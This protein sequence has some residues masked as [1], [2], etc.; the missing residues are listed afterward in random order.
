MAPIGTIYFSDGAAATA[1]IKAI[2]LLAGVEYHNPEG[3]IHY[4]SNKTPEFTAKFPH[5]KV[6]ALETPEGFYL[7]E[8][9]AVARYIVARGNP[10][11][12]VL[13]GV[14]PEEQ[15]LVEQWIHFA[16]T[17][18]Q[19]YSGLLN[20]LFTH[21]IPYSETLHLNNLGRLERSFNTLEAVLKDKTYIVGERLTLADLS[22]AT[23][24]LRSAKVFLGND[25]IP[26]YS[27]V[28]RHTEF[29]LTQPKIA[30]FW[31]V[32]WPEKALTYTPPAEGT[33]E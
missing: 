2:A 22:V 19:P 8:S 4:K 20:G 3:Y 10:E 5:G 18:V 14:T 16:D 15:A 1:R 9:S 26:K 28:V 11:A 21:K 7:A 30:Q 17:E 24:V 33:K 23:I 12:S 13:L 31:N 6:P 25:N 27:S 32:K 29:I